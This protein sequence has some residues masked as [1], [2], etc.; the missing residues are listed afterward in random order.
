MASLDFL[1]TRL[2][3]LKAVAFL[4]ALF[5]FISHP[6]MLDAQSATKVIAHRGFWSA[7]GSAQNSLKSL[8]MCHG[9]GIYGCEFDVNMT[10]DGVLV[11]CH[12]PQVSGI[13]DIQKATYSEAMKVRLENG[14]KLPTLEE[15]LKAAKKGYKVKNA[16]GKSVL[17]KTH[18]I[19][20]IKSGDS[21]MEDEVVMKC[22]ALIKNMKLEERMTIISFSLDVCAKIAKLLP[23]VSVQY[24]MGDKSPQELKALGIN[25]IDYHYSLL[26][27]NEEMIREAHE[28]GMEVNVWTVDKPDQIDALARLG[29]DY[30][31]TNEPLVAKEILSGIR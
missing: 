11:V 9:I 6:C 14:E 2:R 27:L 16:S 8:E 30:I 4:A 10:F 15:Y 12:G 24:L 3:S 25:G 21:A 18:L 13:P 26:L 1:T 17:E 20:E 23:E 31:T 5:I 29:V 28:L 22:A 19:M 7:E